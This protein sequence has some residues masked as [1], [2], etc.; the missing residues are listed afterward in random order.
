V[1]APDTSHPLDGLGPNDLDRLLR[2][3]PSK[4]GCASIGAPNR[5]A[6][7]NGVQLQTTDYVEA[8]S[9]ANAWG[10]SAGIAAI[11]R[12][13]R[14]VRAQ[15]PGGPTLFVGD[16]SAEHGGYLKPHRSH[17]SG[18][19]ADL[20]YFYVDE[21]AWYAPATKDN[22]DRPR[23]WALVKALIAEGEVEYLFIDRTVQGWLREHAEK[24]GDDPAWL[25]QVFASDS[26]PEAMVRHTWGHRSHLHVRFA[27]P[28]ARETGRRLHPLLV[29]SGRLWR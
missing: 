24:A 16:I 12:A 3:D 5:G 20:G 13:A 18:L 19:D 15:L 7:F 14:A 25:A 1:A 11:D 8:V 4:L 23:T 26:N 27:D 29:R 6:L 21:S 2:E 28:I 22:L 9:P 10:T 17:Q